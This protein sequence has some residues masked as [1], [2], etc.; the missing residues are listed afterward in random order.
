MRLLPAVRPAAVVA[1]AVVAVAILSACG[2]PPDP[3]IKSDALTVYTSLPLSGERGPEGR[4]VLRGEKIALEDAGARVGQFTVA[5]DAIDDADPERGTWSP[6]Q[7]AQNARQAAGNG[8]TIAY[9]GDLDSGATAVSLPVN[10]ELGILQVSPLSGYTGLTRVLDKGEP[11]KYYPADTRTFARLVPTGAVEAR[12]LARWLDGLGLRRVVVAQDGLDDGQGGLIDL[13]DAFDAQRIELVK[14]VRVDP[15]PGHDLDGDVA[16]LVKQKADALVYAGGDS[17]AAARLLRAVHAAA[18]RLPLFVT[19]SSTHGDLAA[20]LGRAA[21]AVRGVSPLVGLPDDAASRAFA[22]RYR[23]AFGADPPPAARYGYE[24]MR[25]VIAAIGRAGE[26][27][28]DRRSVI[29]AYL[30]TRERGT[31]IGDYRIDSS[32]DVDRTEV[33]GFRIAGGELRLDRRLDGGVG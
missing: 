14:A 26:S 7:A 24:A 25:T 19:S 22:R 31:V 21:G 23:A 30:G 18:A 12:A 5:L 15:R 6:D 27:A 8:T 20:R 17:E 33:G 9:I 1:G 4:A 2:S 3:K 10:N 28:K 13:S 16:D 32:G 29:R 11:Q